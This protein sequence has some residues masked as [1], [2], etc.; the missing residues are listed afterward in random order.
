[1][2]EWAWEAT[3]ATSETTAFFPSKLRL[4]LHF[5]FYFAITSVYITYIISRDQMLILSPGLRP[6]IATLIP[7]Q[8]L[9]SA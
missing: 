8:S 9:P 5:S 2:A 4:T 7:Q 1:M 3:T 6:D